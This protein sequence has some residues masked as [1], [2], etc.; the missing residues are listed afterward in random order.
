MGMEATHVKLEAHKEK[1]RVVDEFKARETALQTEMADLRAMLL[2]EKENIE[3]NQRET[4]QILETRVQLEASLAE[5]QGKYDNDSREWQ[6]KLAAE[7]AAHKQDF[8]RLTAE[9][10]AHNKNLEEYQRTSKELESQ[11][12]AEQDAHNRDVKQYEQMSKELE[13]K[14]TAE[15]EAHKKDLKDLEAEKEAR[16]R[17]VMRYE[18]ASQELAAKLEAEKEAHDRDLG[19]LTTEQEKYQRE[20]ADYQEVRRRFACLVFDYFFV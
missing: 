13:R 17:D 1:M 9:L 8:F 10:A 20:L 18:Q 7:E 2:Q 15:L 6:Q 14:L 19:V 11:L 4:G 12:T 16:I 5:L 3:A